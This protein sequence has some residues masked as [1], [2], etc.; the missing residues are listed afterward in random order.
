MC[1]LF[2]Q[3]GNRE[4]KLK[5]LT[6]FLDFL[7]GKTAGTP[8]Q[9]QQQQ[10][11]LQPQPQTQQQQQSETQQQKNVQAKGGT[12]P[13]AAAASPA[14]GDAPNTVAAPAAAHHPPAPSYTPPSYNTVLQTITALSQVWRALIGRTL[15]VH[16]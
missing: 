3:L 5:A 13:T 15:T 16:D 6:D 1:A 4:K 8:P 10:Q 7:L 9:Q 14:V 2:L 11:Q 12:S